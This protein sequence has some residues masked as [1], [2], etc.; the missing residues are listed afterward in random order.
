M[1]ASSDRRKRQEAIASGLDKKTNA[2]LEEQKKQRKSKFNWIFGSIVVALLIAA[3]LILNSN[4]FYTRTTAVQ[5]GDKSYTTAQFNYYYKTQY[6]NFMQQYG[7][8]ASYFG[9]DTDQ[10]LKSQTCNMMEDGGTWYDYFKQSALNMMA[11]VTALSEYAN[12]NGI[13]LE[14]SDTAEIDSEMSQLAENAVTNKYSSTK[15]Y[16]S[17]LFGRGCTE[18]VVR[19]EM[20]RSALATKAYNTVRDSYTFTDAELEKEYQDNKD[21]FDLFSFDYYLVAA[22]KVASDKTTATDATGT[23][24]DTADNSAVTAETM[25]AAKATADNIAAAAKTGD[26]TKAVSDQVADATPTAQTD[27]SGSNVASDYAE[28]IKS[29]DRHAGD[30]TVVESADNGYYVV[31]YNG[32]SDNHYQLAEARHILIKAAAD[33]DGKYTDEAKAE[34]K[35]KL[36]EI[37]DEWLKGD[38]TEKSF[39]ALAEKYSEDAGSNTN[40]G[41]YDEIYK[42]QTVEEFDK[43]CFAEGR[44]PGDTAIVYGETSEYAGYHLVYYVGLNDELYSSYLAKNQLVSDKLNAWQTELFKNY[45]TTTKFPLRFANAS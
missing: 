32:R 11:Q 12:K 30:V 25:A 9:L 41:L 15:N 45:T 27:V 16:L 35:A 2:S 10:P 37:Y 17:A 26:F 42:G 18:E 13:K 4:L 43:F 36:Q 33:D 24:T 34:A 44:K 6:Y 1:S 21:S 8:Y 3:I 31:K 39:A 29:A 23:D 38:K 5:V 28:W 20:E 40:G 14:E 7:S 19:A 22:E